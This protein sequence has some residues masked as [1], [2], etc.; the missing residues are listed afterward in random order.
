[1]T[2]PTVQPLISV[3]TCVFNE[4]DIIEHFLNTLIALFNTLD[5]QFEIICVNDGSTDSTL[6]KIMPYTEQDNNIHIKII[7]LSRNFGKEAALTAGL[8]HANGNAIIP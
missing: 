4:E 6:K 7:D 2:T 3:V 8:N 1:M 5:F